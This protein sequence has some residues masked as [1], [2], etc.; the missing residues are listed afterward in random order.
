MKFF[1]RWG[2]ARTRLFIPLETFLRIEAASGI[3]L[4]AATVCALLWANSPWSISYGE[5]WH[6]PAGHFLI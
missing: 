3:V 5:L 1:R 2:S 4:L 6:A